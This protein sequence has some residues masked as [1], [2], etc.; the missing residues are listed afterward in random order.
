MTK[1]GLGDYS[2][3]MNEET[4]NTEGL[5]LPGRAPQG[6]AQFQFYKPQPNGEYLKARDHQVFIIFI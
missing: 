4:G 1:G 3:P 6:P 2:F 5:F